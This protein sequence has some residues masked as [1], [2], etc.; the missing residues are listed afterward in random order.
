MVAV[1]AT[2][3]VPPGRV[4]SVRD[5]GAGKTASVTGP[6]MVLAGLLESVALTV[7][8]DTPAVVGVPVTRQPA[9]S[10]SPAGI[11]PPVITQL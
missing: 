10:E 11:I 6:V 3:T 9:P 8:I 4:A 7:T 1:Y 2:P 5:S